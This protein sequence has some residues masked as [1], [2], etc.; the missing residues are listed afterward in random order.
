GMAAGI[1]GLR[2]MPLGLD[3][4]C[5]R[6]MGQGIEWMISVALWVTSV[7]GAVGRMAAFGTGPL[8]LCTAGLVVLCLLKT[9]LRFIGGLLIGGAIVV[10]IRGP[11]ADVLVVPGGSAAAG[12]GES[13]RFSV[14][15]SGSRPLSIA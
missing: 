7:P 4:L 1:L 5:W 8:L 3:G 14:V 2:S 6:L 10:V 9:P 12:P 13:G 11:Q 15:K